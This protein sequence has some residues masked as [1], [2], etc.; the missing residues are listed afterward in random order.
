LRSLATFSPSPYRNADGSLTADAVAGKA[1]FE[2][3][4]C[5]GCHGGAPF[6]VS[7]GVAGLRDVGTIKPASGNR[8]GAALSGIDVPTLRDVWATAP[9]LHDGSAANLSAA[10]LAHAGTTITDTDLTNLVSYLRQIGSEELG[11]GVSVNVPPSV[12]LTSPA[13]GATFT[14]GTAITLSANA[15]D[16]DGSVSKVEFFDGNTLVGTDSA[17]PY[18]LSWTGAATGAHTLAARAQDNAGATTTSASVSITVTAPLV[19]PVSVGEWTFN[20][21]SGTTSPDTS[22]K[23]KTLTLGTGVRFVT[24]G[25]VGP[26]LQLLGTSSPNGAATSSAVVTTS[27]SFSV[28]GW[29]RFDQLPGCKNQAMASQDASNVSGFTLGITGPCNGQQ[30]VFTFVMRSSNSSFATQNTA[31]STSAPALTRWYHLTGV[32]NTTANTMALYV[33]GAKV[34]TITNSAKWSATGAFVVGRA[35]SSGSARDPAYASIDSVRAFNRA[36]TDAEVTTL[37]QAAR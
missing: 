1:V 8:L 24:N 27:T 19:L 13:A 16:T 30:G 2:A 21:A 3:K 4:G 22:G 29:I 36:L 7:A 25:L 35:K 37:F 18:T 5:G 32:R 28:S 12:A 23:G 17:A 10:V 11:P 34:R 20:T 33:D 15:A 14:Q 31:A 6:T 9:Y 26:A